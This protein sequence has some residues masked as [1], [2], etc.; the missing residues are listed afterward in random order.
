M[1]VDKVEALA[2]SLETN[3][4]QFNLSAASKLLW[5]SFRTPYVVYDKRAAIALSRNSA[6]KSIAKNY[7]NFTNAWRA[8][9]GRLFKQI[10]VAVANLPNAREFMPKTPLSN[11]ELAALSTQSWFNERVFDIFLWEVG[12]AG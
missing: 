11:S 4:C 7:T 1:P 8:E 10:K 12:G 6:H 5:L 2:A 3:F 9:Y